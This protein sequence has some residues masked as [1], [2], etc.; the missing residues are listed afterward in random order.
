DR[1][2]GQLHDDLDEVAAAVDVISNNDAPWD[3]WNRLGMAIWAATQGTGYHVFDKWS[4]RAAKYNEKTTQARWTNFG[5]SPPNRIGAGTLF[6]L[7]EREK[8]GWR[9]PLKSPARIQQKAHDEQPRINE[10]PRPLIRELPQ[11][12]AFPIDEL[13]TVLAP[14]ARAIHERTRG[15]LAICGQSVLAAATLVTQAHANIELPNGQSVPLSTYLL[16]VA[17]TGER[18][19]AV[20]REAL[21]PVR[22]R[23]QTLREEYDAKRGD[24]TNATAAFE[25]ARECV[26]KDGKGDRDRI[27]RNL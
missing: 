20:D 9:R 2:A 22:K 5:K 16:S 3:E 6:W 26:L 27:K 23:E 17:V 19:S 11:A 1:I 12:D 14:A 4:A 8:P 18:K 15:P 13:G 25:K 24:Y 7:A 21:W 10:A